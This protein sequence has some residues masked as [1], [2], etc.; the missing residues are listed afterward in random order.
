MNTKETLNDSILNDL[1]KRANT[2]RKD[3]IEMIY[4]AKSGHPGGS[5]SSADI[6]TALY[7]HIMNHNPK[8]PF[9]AGRDR[10]ILSKGHA[11]PSL[12]AALAES[13]YFDVSELKN[14]RK[15]KC[16]LQ[17]HPCTMTPGIEISTG[18]LGQGLSI[19]TGIALGLRLDGSSSKVFALLGDGELQSGQI[20]EAMMAAP[21][22]KLGNL[23]AII[24]RNNLQIDG[25][26]EK[27]MPLEPL[28]SKIES[29][30]WQVY[31]IDGHNIR[32]I[33]QTI[34]RGFKITDKPKMI[35][36]HTV[37]GKGVSF[38]E[39]NVSFHGKSPNDEEYRIAM[40]EL[41][42]NS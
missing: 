31:E 35:I 33:I 10:F 14:L 4:S 40:K 27:V 26:T 42:A 29:F 16:L 3:I 37:K 38:M 39:N 15:P 18:S 9:W 30:N 23:T 17:G 5:L 7:F 32:E 13:G 12:Y 41:E 22:F 2:I 28:K 24:D 36:A 34:N 21:N 25:P 8:D 11:C 20:W 6:V 1:K 19:A